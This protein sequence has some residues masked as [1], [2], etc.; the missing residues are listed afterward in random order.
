[1]RGNCAPFSYL[2]TVLTVG[3]L[4]PLL[5]VVWTS[6]SESLAALALALRG[7]DFLAAGFL[8]TG[9]AFFAGAA[10]FAGE[11]AARL[12]F[13]GGACIIKRKK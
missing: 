9:V 2:L 13:A 3:G 5:G 10:F 4:L 12:R 6:S 7:V 8:A 1:M 11:A